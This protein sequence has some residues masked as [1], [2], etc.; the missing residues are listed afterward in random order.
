M[1]I[2]EMLKNLPSGVPKYIFN[3]QTWRQPQSVQHLMDLTYR[4]KEYKEGK[5][6]FKA[7][8]VIGT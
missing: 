5:H 1:L 8:I 3:N 6:K 2:E 7:I 4:L